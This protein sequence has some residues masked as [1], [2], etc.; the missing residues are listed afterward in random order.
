MTDQ[1]HTE[2]KEVHF[3]EE[4]KP[5]HPVLRELS[6]PPTLAQPRAENWHGIEVVDPYA[7][8]EETNDPTSTW[9]DAQNK[10]SRKYFDG[11]PN[12]NQFLTE[13]QTLSQIG[14]IGC[15]TVKGK[16]TFL[17]RRTGTQDQAVLYVR[18][19]RG[20]RVL[21][22]PNTIGEGETT[23][24]DWEEHN[25]RGEYL[26]YGTSQGGSENSVLKIKNVATGEDLADQIPNTAYC[27]LAWLPDNSGFY[28]TRFVDPNSPETEKVNLANASRNVFFHKIGSDWKEDPV[29]FSQEEDWL[30]VEHSEDGKWIA[31][32]RF[33]GRTAQDF[34]ICKVRTE[35]GFELT[36]KAIVTGKETRNYVREYDNYAYIKTNL[37]ASRY[38]IARVSLD[39][40]DLTDESK[41]EE[42]VPEQDATL[43]NYRIIGGKLVLKYQDKGCSKL[44]VMDLKTKQRQNIELPT[45]GDVGDFTGEQ[46]KPE[47]FYSFE[48]FGTPTTIFKINLDTLKQEQVDQLQVGEDLSDI[49]TEQVAYQSEDGTECS[50]FIVHKGDTQKNG[51]GKTILSGYGAYGEKETPT[52]NRSLIPWLNRGGI[53]AIANIRGGGEYGEEWHRAGSLENK[54]NT[55]DDFIAGAEY[56]VKEG[57]TSPKRLALRGGSAGGLLVGAVM[58]QRPDICAAV[59]ADVPVLDMLHYANT[60]AGKLAL[61]EFG[62]P[63]NPEQFRYLYQNSPYHNV[64]NNTPY[65][66]MLLL[67]GENDSRVDPFHARK[68]AARLQAATS[69]TNPI[70]LSVETKTGHGYGSPARKIAEQRADVYSFLDALLDK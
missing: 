64:K 8:L 28:Y 55:F 4:A 53:Y 30:G 67:T 31:F 38:R 58:V 37:G 36:P 35:G 51:S 18:D 23:A 14:G 29:I 43:D 52:F 69:S 59:V 7:W 26:A 16:Y 22:D 21:I 27:S 50:M 15:P 54:Q 17:H 48:S 70:L 9:Q 34:Y 63:N 33:R 62:D 57:Y 24:I 41:W 25:H 32:A 2:S 5:F 66:A 49:V 1:L 19:D 56:L 60:V 46:N 10:L 6:Y 42:L 13:F 3:P 20:E 65:P 47:M 11:L 40:E 68:M 39:E 61:S 45:L 44:E 12:R